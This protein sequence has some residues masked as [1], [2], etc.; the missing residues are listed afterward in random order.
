MSIMELTPGRHYKLHVKEDWI[1]A[2]FLYI[3]S[4]E[5][6]R[7]HFIFCDK[8]DLCYQV[9]KLDVNNRVRDIPIDPNVGVKW[10]E[11]KPDW[12]L[13]DL[14]LIEGVVKVLTHGAK[15]YD[16]NNWQ[17]VPD[18][19]DRYYSG[20]MRHITAYKTGE[21]NDPESTLPHIYHALCCLLFVLWFELKNRRETP[22]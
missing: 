19:K 11:N 22:K 3:H 12:S 10:D 9:E 16:R 7:P 21:W 14:S 15:K 5:G 18:G 1:D 20:M 8:N 4:N 6:D 2:T 17:G 13:L